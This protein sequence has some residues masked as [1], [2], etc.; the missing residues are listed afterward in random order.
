MDG[1]WITGL[2]VGVPLAGVVI[3]IMNQS[4]RIGHWQ[5]S[6]DELLKGNSKRMDVNDE[7]ATKIEDRHEQYV[8]DQRSTCA[9]QKESCGKRIDYIQGRVNHIKEK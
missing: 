1:A 9:S 4:R 6:V 2:S 3:A 8:R 5:G 7:R